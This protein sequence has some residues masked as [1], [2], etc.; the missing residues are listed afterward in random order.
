M[1]CGE[2]CFFFNDTA[3][4]EIYTLSLPDAL[5]ISCAAAT[6]AAS[7]EAA[8]ARWAAAEGDAASVAAPTAAMR[9]FTASTYQSARSLH[10]N[11][12]HR[13]AASSSRKDSRW[14]VAAAIV[15]YAWP[16]I[17]RSASD[18]VA[19]SRSSMEVTRS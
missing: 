14:L 9:G 16:R 17:Q 15:L 13:F 18:S 8:G 4:T 10:A 7:P 11:S 2:I 5:P 1:I 12:K 19:G 3:T 6:D